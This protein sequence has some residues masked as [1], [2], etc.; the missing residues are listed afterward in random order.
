MKVKIDC[1]LSFGCAAEEGL[2]KNTSEAI[3]LEERGAEVNIHRIDDKK[4]E[5]LGLK[6][7]PTIFIDGIELQPQ[8]MGGFF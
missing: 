6:G 3:K 4:A 1:Y 5:E 2:R 7:S 8:D